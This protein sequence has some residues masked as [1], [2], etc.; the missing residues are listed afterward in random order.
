MGFVRGFTERLR[1]KASATR[2][3]DSTNQPTNQTMAEEFD[4]I[5][6]GRRVGWWAAEA[7]P[8][9]YTPE[10]TPKHPNPPQFTCNFH[11]TPSLEPPH[12]SP[13]TAPT[14]SFA[15]T[16]P[17]RKKSHETWT[18]RMGCQYPRGESS[19]AISR[20]LLNMALLHVHRGRCARSCFL[21]QASS[22]LLEHLLLRPSHD[23]AASQSSCCWYVEPLAQDINPSGCGDM[24][25]ATHVL[26]LAWRLLRRHGREEKRH[27]HGKRRSWFHAKLALPKHARQATRTSKRE[28]ILS[29]SLRRPV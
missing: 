20:M 9:T 22:L 10:P 28:R 24:D 6:Q 18:M 15:T 4:M 13:G 1:S 17:A 7:L 12:L 16:N 14:S 27:R 29:G 19:Y 8:F 23:L 11:R 2:K 3:E 26:L 21:T 25:L 5:V